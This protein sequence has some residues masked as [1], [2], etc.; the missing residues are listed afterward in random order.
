MLR[1][2]QTARIDEKGRIKVP[3]AYRHFIAEKYGDEFFVTSIDGKSARLYPLR[4]W[5]RIEARVMQVPDMDP[6]RQKFLD[7]TSYYG[8]QTTMDSQGRI[9]IHPKLRQ[10]AELVSDVNV[11]GYLTYLDVWNKERFEVRLHSRPIISEDAAA[12][13]RLGI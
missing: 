1:G 10:E 3:A 4:E 2:N 12:I 11:L 8:Q 7:W 6:A 9:L 5:E 13:A